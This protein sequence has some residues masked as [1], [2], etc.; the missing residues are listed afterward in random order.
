MKVGIKRKYWFGYKWYDC[1]NFYFRAEIKA[2]NFKNTE[3]GYLLPVIWMVI[4]QDSKSVVIPM[5]DK[6]YIVIDDKPV[7]TLVS[8]EVASGSTVSG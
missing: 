2:K 1:S 5:K 3:S 7:V 8:E 4:V 6:E